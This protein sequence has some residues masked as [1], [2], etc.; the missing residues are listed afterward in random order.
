MS[1]SFSY[2]IAI[3]DLGSSN[4][5]FAKWRIPFYKQY[6]PLGQMVPEGLPVYRRLTL[7][8]NSSIGATF[9]KFFFV[10]NSL[11]NY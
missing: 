11:A 10:A 6:A 4:G 2:V 8:S 3:A 9:C 7:H 1:T 5:A